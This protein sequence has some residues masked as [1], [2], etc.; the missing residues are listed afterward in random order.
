MKGQMALMAWIRQG[1]P[2]GITFLT[3][4]RT[5]R[6]REGIN[7]VTD[8]SQGYRD[9]PFPPFNERK[10]FREGSITAPDVR[11]RNSFAE[12]NYF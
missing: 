5:N 6:L 10:D 7:G 12:D 4:P 2:T 8:D 11:I 1:K 3:G 9:E